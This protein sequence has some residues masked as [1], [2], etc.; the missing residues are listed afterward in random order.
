MSISQNVKRCY[1]SQLPSE[2]LTNEI[3]T[4]LSYQDIKNTCLTNTTFATCCAK[5][6]WGLIFRAKYPKVYA[7]AR[8]YQDQYTGKDYASIV[9]STERITNNEVKNIKPLT[10]ELVIYAY[11][12]KDY[13]Y[14]WATLFKR[15]DH[16]EALLSTKYLLSLE[17]D[18]I[19]P[20]ADNNYAFR[21]AAK[22]G[23]VEVLQFLMDLGD[24]RIDPSAEDNYAFR[25]ATKKGHVEVL[26]FLVDLK[27][28]RID[29]SASDNYAFRWAAANGYV[30]VLQFLMDLEDDRVDPS[31]RDN[32]S[33]QGAAANGHVEVLQFLIDLGDARIDPSARDN[34]AF[35]WAA[36]NGHVEVLQFLMDLGDDRIDPS[37][38][39][40]AAFQLAAVNGHVEVLQFLESLKQLN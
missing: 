20:S 4:T 38:G 36:V 34:A 3:F 29:P 21:W 1:L 23:H 35:R 31:A 8:R 14:N 28:D 11:T 22:K 16:T 30:E 32:Y 10:L 9:K 27:D 6:K 40:N 17:D 12:E 13:I 18:L 5:D 39:D 25:W 19:D 2:L 15:S 33:F 24:D 26:Q 7:I 37:A